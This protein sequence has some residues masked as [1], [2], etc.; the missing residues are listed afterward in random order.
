MGCGVVVSTFDFRRSNRGS[1]PVRGCGI[2][3]MIT[4][5]LYCG[6]IGKVSENHMPRVHRSHVREIGKMETIRKLA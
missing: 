4:T 6:T 2:F 1:N 3:I 5:T